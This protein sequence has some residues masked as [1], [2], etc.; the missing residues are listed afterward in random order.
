MCLS[1]Q[2]TETF[3]CIES[4]LKKSLQNIFSYHM[5]LTLSSIR[6]IRLSKQIDQF[7]VPRTKT[8]RVKSQHDY[9]MNIFPKFNSIYSLEY[10]VPATQIIRVIICHISELFVV[11][12]CKISD[13]PTTTN[14]VVI[15]NIHWALYCLSNTVQAI[16]LYYFT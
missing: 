16:Y 1:F 15:A 8:A 11:V 5:D 14:K 10:S 2:V 13:A 9:P 4:L 7:A 6:E 12:I 3:L